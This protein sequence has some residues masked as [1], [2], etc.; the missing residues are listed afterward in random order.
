MRDLPDDDSW[1]GP[2]RR[3]IGDRIRDERRRQNLS[4]EEVYLKARVDRRTLQVIEA[5]S[6]NPSLTVL[7]RISYVLNF[8]L[9][10]LLAER[11]PSAE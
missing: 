1:M 4:Q 8:P 11:P 10:A 2:Y 3:R 6:G 5:G 7:L 9:D